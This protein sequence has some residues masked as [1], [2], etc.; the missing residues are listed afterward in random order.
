MTARI[1]DLPMTDEEKAKWKQPHEICPMCNRPF[2]SW[3]Q[4]RLDSE[5]IVHKKCIEAAKEA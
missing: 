3:K 2:G 4:K 1:Y 5:V